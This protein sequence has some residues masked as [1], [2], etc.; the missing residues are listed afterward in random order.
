[1]GINLIEA[2]GKT[3]NQGKATDLFPAG[4]SQYL[5]IPDHAIEA[6]EEENGVIK[7]KYTGGVEG[8]EDDDEEE[9]EEN[10]DD[11]NQ[12]DHADVG[13]ITVNNNVIAIYNILGQKQTTTNIEDLTQG[14]YI[15][16]TSSGSKKI[17][18]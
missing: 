6:I 9:D 15:I 1:M 3:S 17:V 5:A 14:T 13:D 11:E 4:A 18:R 7:F 10:K 2:D 12:D 8:E 16:M